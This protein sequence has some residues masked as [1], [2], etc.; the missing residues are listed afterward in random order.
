MLIVNPNSRSGRQG[1]DEKWGRTFGS[2][3]ALDHVE[4]F[5]DAGT[6]RWALASLPNFELDTDGTCA[7]G[8][9]R[10]L[11]EKLNEINT[12]HLQTGPGLRQPQEEL[13]AHVGR[14]GTSWRQP[15]RPLI[16]VA[17]CLIAVDVDI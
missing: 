2:N 13:V 9:V 8:C 11:L 12:T 5:Y 16:I 17:S 3:L 10:R 1:S 6:R 4:W 14:N 7:C 15:G